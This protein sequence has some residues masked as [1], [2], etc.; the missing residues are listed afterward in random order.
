MSTTTKTTTTDNE[1]ER[2]TQSLEISL[3]D[4]RPDEL[5]MKNN[6][7]YV[8][9]CVSCTITIP[10][11]NTFLLILLKRNNVYTLCVQRSRHSVPNNP[12]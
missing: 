11:A 8:C 5:Q 2:G 7:P 4:L 3:T 1:Y 9:Y 6:I 12:K 10:W